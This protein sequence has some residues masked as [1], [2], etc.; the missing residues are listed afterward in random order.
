MNVLGALTGLGDARTDNA[1]A[2]GDTS[3]SA[4]SLQYY[5]DKATE[6]QSVL[7]ALDAGYQ[8]ILRV[9]GTDGI[10]DELRNELQE[11]ANEYVSRRFT[12]KA[13]AE[14]INPVSYTHL[15]A[16]ET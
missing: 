4:F 3:S 2:D 12:L 6:F 8:S 14:A 10:S 16:H 13:T 15:R 7:N 11:M 5:R 9:L 1:N